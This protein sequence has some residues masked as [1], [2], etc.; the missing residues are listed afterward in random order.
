M[1]FDCHESICQTE[2]SV[3]RQWIVSESWVKRQ[4]RERES[5]LKSHQWKR[6]GKAAR[7]KS[8]RM[9]V[10]KIHTKNIM[11]L[12]L[13]AIVVVAARSRLSFDCTLSLLCCCCCWQRCRCFSILSP[14]VKANRL[15]RRAAI[16]YLLATCFTIFAPTP[17]PSP[18][19]TPV[20]TSQRNI[21]RSYP[22]RVLAHK[23]TL[24]NSSPSS[25]SHPH[26]LPP[27]HTTTTILLRNCHTHALPPSDSN[28]CFHV[29]VRAESAD[30]LLLTSHHIYRYSTWP[31]YHNFDS[32]TRIRTSHTPVWNEPN[33]FNWIESNKCHLRLT[34]LQYSHSQ[35][36]SHFTLSHS[37]LSLYLSSYIQCIMQ[38]EHSRRYYSFSAEDCILLSYICARTHTHT[39][40]ARAFVGQCHS[41]CA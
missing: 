11:F 8:A 15:L 14:C 38:F 18:A 22:A 13:D 34:L 23:H 3:N 25:L 30:H 4:I 26:S 7:A 12:Q 36:H 39:Q 27:P 9:P 2:L 33:W 16:D 35:S 29:D 20:S 19:H 32:H 28:D 6:V 10:A 5:S 37:H 21:S 40:H 31:G 24:L 41:T 1:S 17:A